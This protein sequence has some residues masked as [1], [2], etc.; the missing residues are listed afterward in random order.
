MVIVSVFGVLEI[1]LNFF[2]DPKDGK[3]GQSV[4]KIAIKYIERYLVF[5][6]LPL[7]RLDL[8]YSGFSRFV[9]IF[10]VLRLR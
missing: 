4:K 6:I 10:L 9:G 8:I 1:L 7:V 2:R 5:D 3:I